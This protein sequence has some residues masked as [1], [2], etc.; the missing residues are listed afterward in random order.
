MDNGIL[1]LCGLSFACI[2]IHTHVCIYTYVYMYGFL[3]MCMYIRMCILRTHS[4]SRQ[5]SRVEFAVRS[6]FSVVPF[7]IDL[8]HHLFRSFVFSSEFHSSLSIFFSSPSFFFLFLSV[9]GLLVLQS[10][11]VARDKTK[12]LT[13]EIAFYEFRNKSHSN[14]FLERWYLTLVVHTS[15]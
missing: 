11:H 6:E 7:E 12:K 1:L 5:C 10:E 15:K 14:V 8:S 2:Y 9:S 3:N 13:E 4:N